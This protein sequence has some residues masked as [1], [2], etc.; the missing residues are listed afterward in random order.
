V[1]E[2]PADSALAKLEL[3]LDS[4]QH[5]AESIVA[6]ILANEAPCDENLVPGAHMLC[7]FGKWYYSQTHSTVLTEQPLFKSLEKKHRALHDA[8]RVLLAAP[9][10]LAKAAS[11]RQFSSASS[12]MTL[13]LRNLIQALLTNE[14]TTDA[15]TGIPNR[16]Q[17][18]EQLE[19]AIYNATNVL[20]M[21]ACLALADLDHFKRINDT[22][23]HAIG[24]EVLKSF[25][26][27]LI[28]S[29]RDTD[30]IY[31]YGGEEFLIFM[32]NVDLEHAQSILDRLREKIAR[33]PLH[34]EG[35]PNPLH[36]TVSFGIAEVMG[37]EPLRNL[38]RRA[39]EALYQA[40]NAGRNRVCAS[41][42]LVPMK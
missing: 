42:G 5:W 34:A 14:L 26:Q 11:Y 23:G 19:E 41:D 9:A 7:D 35:L 21:P 36:I 31:R 3:T 33:Y 32:Q 25:S 17:M 4:H 39:D 37:K 28:T 38:T 27:L 40:K 16:R 15:L 6:G 10:G 24:D 29:M 13:H 1:S 8:A 22:Y 18:D 12:D 2:H 30:R 20:S